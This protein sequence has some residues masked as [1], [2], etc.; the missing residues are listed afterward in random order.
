MGFQASFKKH[1]NVGEQYKQIGNSVAVPVI[2]AIAESIK[3]Q[4]LLIDEPQRKVVGD[5]QT[6]LFSY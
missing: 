2:R 1:T 3:E 4:K 5:L 6:L